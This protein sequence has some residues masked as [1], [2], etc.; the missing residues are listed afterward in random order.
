LPPRFPMGVLTA[1]TITAS[2]IAV[3]LPFDR[4]R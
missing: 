2:G 1:S 4:A 3:H